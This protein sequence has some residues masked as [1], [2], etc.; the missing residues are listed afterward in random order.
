VTTKKNPYSGRWD[1]PLNPA[2]VTRKDAIL[3]YSLDV[4]Q[5]SLFYEGILLEM[6]P[7][8]Y[9]PALDAWCQKYPQYVST[10]MKTAIQI[11]VNLERSG[12]IPPFAV[13]FCIGIFEELD[14]MVNGEIANNLNYLARFR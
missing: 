6:D 10:L 13:D 2:K 4:I 9:L 3:L 5:T 12:E 11:N 14:L 7:S 1:Q 8:L